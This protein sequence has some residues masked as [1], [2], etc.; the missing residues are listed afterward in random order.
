MTRTWSIDSSVVV[1]RLRAYCNIRVPIIGH[2]DQLATLFIFSQHSDVLGIHLAIFPLSPCFP[3]DPVKCNADLLRDAEQILYVSV[4]ISLTTSLILVSL[5]WPG[6]SVTI[7]LRSL[8]V[9]ASNEAVCPLAAYSY[10]NPEKIRM[11]PEN[12]GP[13][14]YHIA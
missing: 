2:C 9:A 3:K 5:N 6:N 4:R 12:Q 13:S 14:A 8:N 1:P 7:A 11:Q 10:P